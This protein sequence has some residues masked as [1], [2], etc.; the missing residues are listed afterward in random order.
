[1][2]FLIRMCWLSPDIQYLVMTTTTIIRL[3][4]WIASVQLLLMKS[5][6]SLNIWHFC[7]R[8]RGART[9]VYLVVF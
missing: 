2:E 1:M 8:E 6:R 7:V 3:A 4:H 5:K 9:D